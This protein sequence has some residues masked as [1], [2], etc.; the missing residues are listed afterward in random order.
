MTQTADRV[1]ADNAAAWNQTRDWYRD[2]VDQLRPVLARGGSTLHPVEERILRRLPA[3]DEWCERAVHLQCSAGMDTHS[4][5]NHGAREVVGVDIASDLIDVASD[6]SQELGVSSRARF[7]TADVLDLPT[8]LH[9]T[10]D[11]VF[12]GKGAVH[13]IFDLAAWSRSVDL[14]LK[15]GGLFIL[16]DFHAMMWLFRGDRAE[17]EATGLSYFAPVVSYTE[18]AEGHVGDLGIPP[19][20]LETK[21]LRPWPPSA[22]IQSLL[23]RGLELH[24]FGEY[25]DSLSPDWSAYPHWDDAARRTVATTYSIIARKPDD[26]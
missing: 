15:P 19:E 8:D 4:L 11:L 17:V 1:H 21:R 26:A 3:L 20:Q 9:A 12:T 2:R 10:A 16:F 18:W 22:V 25:P 6:L 23:D 7:V 14:L 5:L 13:W 24:A